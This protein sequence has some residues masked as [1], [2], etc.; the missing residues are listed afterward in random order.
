[1]AMGLMTLALL[2]GFTGPVSAEGA[3]CAGGELAGSQLTLSDGVWRLNQRQLSMPYLW[4]WV[5]PVGGSAWAWWFQDE[6]GVRDDWLRSHPGEWGELGLGSTGYD[7]G[8]LVGI[9]QEHLGLRV[10][11]DQ[12]IDADKEVCWDGNSLYLR[13]IER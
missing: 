7:M 12:E 11:G 10:Q 13:S 6:G 2:A 5:N 1:M 4:F 3:Q 9:G 8:L